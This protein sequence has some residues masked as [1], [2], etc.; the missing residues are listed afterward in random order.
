MEP[1]ALGTNQV[2][3]WRVS[4]DPAAVAAAQRM[5][6]ELI[7]LSPA[8]G[9]VVAFQVGALRRRGAG[10]AVHFLFHARRSFSRR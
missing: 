3:G 6:I 7:N 4:D 10:V 2:L 8:G 9:F 5:N 1:L